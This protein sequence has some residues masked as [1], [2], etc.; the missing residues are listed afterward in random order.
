MH[1]PKPAIS[2]ST[3]SAS[4]L[5]SLMP[6]AVIPRYAQL[7]LWPGPLYMKHLVDT[8]SP[9]ARIDL[10]LGVL[11][12]ALCALQILRRQTPST[13]PLSW[14]IIWF[15]G[16]FLPV[17][18]VGDIVYEHWMYLP[19]V[20]LFLGAAQTIAIAQGNGP[21]VFQSRPV[22][23]LPYAVAALLGF[24]T[25]RQNYIWRDEVSFYGHT[26]AEGNAAPE[27]HINLGVYYAGLGDYKAALA[28][29]EA[30][31][32]EFEHTTDSFTADNR[33][34]VENDIAMS[35]LSLP[36]GA[37]RRE[38]AIQHLRKAIEIDPD[39]YLALDNLARLYAQLG[40]KDLADSYARKAREVQRRF[41]GAD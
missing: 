21:R 9:W 22:N 1:Q 3:Q 14:G 34:V 23:A 15:A 33:A 19:T 24:L 16:A 2:G 39:N 37:G 36:D 20:G 18:G 28:Q 31:E 35:L 17:F 13:L 25:W 26:I 10:V 41:N 4:F 5:S 32:T 29:Y 7:L 38:E 27:A 11:I 12:I 8:A 30:A 6:L 40:D